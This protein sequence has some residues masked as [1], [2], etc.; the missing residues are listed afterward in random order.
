[1]HL[2][3][4]G[5]CLGLGCLMTPGLR[6]FGVMY[7]HTFLDL[8]ITRSDIRPHINWAVSLVIAHGH[9]NLSQAFFVGMYGLTY[10]LYHP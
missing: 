6:T 8:Q 2:Y 10:S 9:F 1:M 4:Q 3:Y 7:D 5:L